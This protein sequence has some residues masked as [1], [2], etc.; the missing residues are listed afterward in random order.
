MIQTLVS[1]SSDKQIP[2]VLLCL[3]SLFINCTINSV[4][5]QTQL[6]LFKI[7]SFCFT[8][9]IENLILQQLHYNHAKW[10]VHI[11]F[12]LNRVSNFRVY[13]WF[14]R[15]IWFTIFDY[16]CNNSSLKSMNLQVIDKI[17]FSSSNCCSNWMLIM[18]WLI[19]KSNRSTSR[20]AIFFTLFHF[21]LFK[22]TYL[23]YKLTDKINISPCYCHEGMLPDFQFIWRTWSSFS[24]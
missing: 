21:F 15:K 23:H 12:E 5:F 19:K 16:K 9:S 8:I 14:A 22:S 24:F 4:F 1:N 11:R 18:Q 3:N 7:I 20:C 10:N 6:K 2:F 17:Y 13:N